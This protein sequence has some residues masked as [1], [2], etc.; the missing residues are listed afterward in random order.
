MAKNTN[1]NSYYHEGEATR[2]QMRGLAYFADKFAD[3]DFELGHFQETPV[4]SQGPRKPIFI[5]SDVANNFVT[6]CINEKLVDLRI[7]TDGINWGKIAMGGNITANA[8]PHNLITMLTHILGDAVHWQC[9]LIKAFQSGLL[10][11][12]LDRGAVFANL[13]VAGEPLPLELAD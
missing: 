11:G 7:D 6:Y 2:R 9:R 5:L 12:I 3:A 8:S 10:Q 4:K 1:L 13:D